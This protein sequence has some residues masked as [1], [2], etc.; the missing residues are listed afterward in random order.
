MPVAM[1]LSCATACNRTCSPTRAPRSFEH[2]CKAGRACC[3]LFPAQGGVYPRRCLELLANLVIELLRHPSSRVPRPAPVY[4][5]LS[6]NKG[7][8]HRLL[9]SVVFQTLEALSKLALS[10]WASGDVGCVFSV[11]PRLHFHTPYI[12]LDPD[13]FGTEMLHLLRTNAEQHSLT[14]ACIMHKIGFRSFPKSSRSTRKTLIT[15]ELPS[16]ALKMRSPRVTMPRL[17]GSHSN[18]KSCRRGVG[19]ILHL[20]DNLVSTPIAVRPNPPWAMCPPPLL[21]ARGNHNHNTP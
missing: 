16:T 13:L 4:P 18:G 9:R 21:G 17:P 11:R 8:N 1:P 5:S 12:P 2:A 15:S 19:C 20:S 14:S 6:K 7:A 10:H 3:E